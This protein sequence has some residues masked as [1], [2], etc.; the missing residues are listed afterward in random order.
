M[1][2]I[3][4][5]SKLINSTTNI[6]IIYYLSVYYPE[7]IMIRGQSFHNRKNYITN[8]FDAMMKV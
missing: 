8:R 1:S 6:A 4:T 7:I 3:D 5:F 2:I